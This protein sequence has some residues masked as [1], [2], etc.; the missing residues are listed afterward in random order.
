MQVMIRLAIP[1]CL[2]S[3][4]ISHPSG[5]LAADQEGPRSSVMFDILT[6]AFVNIKRHLMPT[7]RKSD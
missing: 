5:N 6:Q 4:E 7:S 1:G 2:G 3:F